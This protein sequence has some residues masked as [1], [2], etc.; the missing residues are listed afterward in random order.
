M[1]APLVY[2]CAFSIFLSLTLLF[3]NKGYKG[4]N[5]FLSGYLLCSSFFL[6]TQYILI[7]SKSISLIAFSVSGI[8]SLFFLIGPFAYFYVRSILRDN[9]K[10]TKTD[11]LHFLPFLL[12]FIGAIPFLFSSWEYKFLLAK[13][14]AGGEFMQSKHNINFLL[15]FVFDRI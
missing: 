7:Y 15:S 10:L 11:F 3:F 8:P 6:V 12:I 13:S 2:L 9:V 4:A 1:N 14:I 5:S